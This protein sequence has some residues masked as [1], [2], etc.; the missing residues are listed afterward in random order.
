MIG[1]VVS[2]FQG[3]PETLY[4]ICMS[5]SLYIL[6]YAVIDALM[7]VWKSYV[8]SVIICVNLR[9][10]S[11]IATDESLPFFLSRFQV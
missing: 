7:V 8:A 1:S 2:P 4:A 5:H 6:P 9:L 10:G 11:D 3:C